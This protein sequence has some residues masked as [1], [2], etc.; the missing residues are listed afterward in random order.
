MYP[1]DNAAKNIMTV[2]AWKERRLEPNYAGLDV[3]VLD[4][5]GQPLAGYTL[6]CDVRDS[7]KRG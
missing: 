5:T 2:S 1:F 3:D 6:L 7:H 4:A